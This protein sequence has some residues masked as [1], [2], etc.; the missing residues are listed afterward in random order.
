MIEGLISFYKTKYPKT[1]I[2]MLQRTEYEAI[3]YLKWHWQTNNFDKVTKRGALARTRRAKLLLVF[4]QVGILVQIILSILLIHQGFYLEEF[5]RV[6]L[7]FCVL[8]SY[9]LVWA[10]LITVPLLL[11]KLFIAAPKERR[12]IIA[13]KK[14]FEHTK[15]IKIAVAGSYGKTTMKELLAEVLSESKRV[16]LT[17]ANKN[18]AS[19]HAQFAAKLTGEEEVLV[20]EFGEGKAGDVVKFTDTIKP[21]IGVITG[22][23]PA[24]LD[25]YKDLAEAG[26]DIFSLADYLDNKK[27]YVNGESEAIDSFIKP[28]QYVYSYQGVGD[29]KVKNIKVDFTGTSF[30]LYN[31]KQSLKLKSGLLG[32]HQVGPLAAVAT[33]ALSLGLEPKQVQAGIAKT[34]P[35]EHRMQPRLMAGAWVIDDTYNGNIDGIRAGLRLLS[36]L[37]AQ[38]KIYITPGLVD[39]GVENQAVH[40][41]MGRL[42]A[43]ANPDRVVLMRNSVSSIIQNSL[44]ESG[45]KG[46]LNIENDPLN[47]YTNMEQFLAA[48]DLVM[49]QNDWP[50]NYY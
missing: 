36:D 2:Y 4:L 26:R 6:E 25:H 48:G 50:D 18:V 30:E 21:D 41:T 27:V 37:T 22:L 3:P 46:E 14:I 8:I 49:M 29:F 35:F 40:E 32:K 15:A 19:S 1:L 20:I 39:Q 34:V 11:A 5:W 16:A 31:K 43:E 17:P 28:S 9:P 23:A 38:R 10:Y 44:E 47:F 42:I 33:I 7:G 13:S 24:H 45:Y 12:Q